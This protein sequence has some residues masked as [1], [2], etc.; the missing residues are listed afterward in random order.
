MLIT[1]QV[2]VVQFDKCAVLCSRVSVSFDYGDEE[3]YTD[4][5]DLTWRLLQNNF[6]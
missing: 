5:L 3:A 2:R 6:L 1:L 4:D